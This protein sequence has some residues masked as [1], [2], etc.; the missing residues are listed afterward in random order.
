MPSPLIDVVLAQ[1]DAAQTELDGIVS[2]AA[3]ESRDLTPDESARFDALKGSLSTFDERVKDLRDLDARAA[4][5]AE[6]RKTVAEPDTDPEP[7]ARESN[8]AALPTAKVRSEE[9]VYRN[10]GDHSYLRDLFNAQQGD[11]GAAQRLN[12]NNE[13]Y[14]DMMTRS[15]LT[16]T[17]G[18]G[19]AFA[20]PVYQAENWIKLA[21]AG[22]PFANACHI[23]DLPAGVPS[24]YLPHVTGG[25]A[26]ATQATQNTAVTETDLT[27]EF[28]SASVETIAGNQT[29]SLQL[30]EQ[31]PIPVD[32]VVFDDLTRALATYVDTHVLNGSGSSGQSKGILQVSGTTTVTYTNASPT[33]IGVFQAI[34]QAISQAGKNRFLPPTHIWMHPSRWY[35]L[36]AQVDGNNR[37]LVVPDAQGPFNALASYESDGAGET[38]L[39]HIAGI[40]VYGDYS[41]P[42]N[43]GA[44]TNQDTVIV[45]RND[46]LWLWEGD[47]NVRVLPQTLGANLSMLL[48][49]YRYE[50]FIGNRYASSTAICGGTGFVVPSGY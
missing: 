12:R 10:R 36:A 7:E 4:A 33:A 1:R 6:A 15:G 22:R 19:G 3:T 29:V 35:W 31:S 27:D 46:D 23:Q 17:V 11:F 26:V 25:T 48:Q 38:L 30:I 2:K 20:P 18:A 41:I 21:R 28:I 37:P 49:V 44:G 14:V 40:P 47:L 5:D 32:D 24:I 43:L 42:Q 45:T 16:T 9:M 13:Q 50:L 8:I 39:G 34:L